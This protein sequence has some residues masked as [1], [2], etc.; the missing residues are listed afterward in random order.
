MVITKV[1]DRGSVTLLVTDPATPAA[2]FAPYFD[3]LAG[4]LNKSFLVGDS[5]WLPFRLA[6]KEARLAIHSLLIAFLPEDPSDLFPCLAESILNSKNIRILAARYLNPNT[7]SRE[8][9]SG[10]SV[11]VSVHPGDVPAMGSSIRL[12]SRSPT[13]ER[14][15]P[16]TGTRSVRTAEAMVTSPPGVPR[17]TPSAPFAPSTT[18]E[19][20]TIAPI[21]PALEVATLRL[22]LAVALPHRPAVLAVAKATPPDIRIA[23]AAPRHPLSG[24]QPLPPR[25]IPRPQPQMRWTQPPTSWSSRP[26]P[27]PIRCLQSAFEM[28]TPRARRTTAIQAPVGPIQDSQSLIPA[29]PVSPSPMSR[30][31]SGLAR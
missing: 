11:I 10:T 23:R 2:A 30:T 16:Q 15:F 28:A 24:V 25:L 7:Q 29:E 6:P 8:G 17:L 3:L 22:L 9:K 26:P 18:P 13:I 27:S 31:P 14:A 20:H 21:P 19:P 5:P 1:N 4:Q 12:F